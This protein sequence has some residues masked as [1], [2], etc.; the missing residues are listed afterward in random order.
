[1]KPTRSRIS[2]LCYELYKIDWKE[3]HGITPEIEANTQR[4]FFNYDPE[5]LFAYEDYLTQVGYSGKNGVVYVDYDEFFEN[6]YQDVYYITE[7]LGD[8]KLIIT[9][10]REIITIFSDNLLKNENE[11]N[12]QT[13]SDGVNDVLYTVMDLLCKDCE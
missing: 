1:M 6:E 10:L 2:R 7:L 13:Y 4:D 11:H 5:L 12:Y 8:S 9:Y 3:S